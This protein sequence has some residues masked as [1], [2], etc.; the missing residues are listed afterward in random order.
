MKQ[1]EIL[2]ENRLEKHTKLRIG[3][4]GIVLQNEQLLACHEEKTDFWQLPGGG[5]EAGETLRECCAR[6]LLEETGYIVKP[7][8]RFLTLN[9]YYQE[10]K[11]VSHY[12]L[13]EIVGKGTLN[14][15]S[16]EIKRGLVPRWIRLRDFLDIV[17][18]CAA[19]AAIDEDKYGA[20]LRE[21]TALRAYLHSISF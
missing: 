10:Y 12:F 5:L 2:G 9:E 14:R 19:Y 11:Y 13:C 8:K 7:I 16:V 4:R 3:C 18:G 6:E 1:L 20:Y 17:G 15:T 21:D